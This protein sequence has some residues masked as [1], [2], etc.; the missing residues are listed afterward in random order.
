MP[1]L[2]SSKGNV[3]I[4]PDFMSVCGVWSGREQVACSIEAVG[5]FGRVPVY[6]R[7]LDSILGLLR[8]NAGTATITTAFVLIHELACTVSQ[9]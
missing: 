8:G 7:H 5:A 9:K 4:L 6:G 2:I 1:C 3:G